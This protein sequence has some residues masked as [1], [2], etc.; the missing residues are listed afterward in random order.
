MGAFLVS[1]TLTGNSADIIEDAIASVVD[2]VDLCL[3]IDTGVT[4]S[5]REIAKRVAKE[6][7]VE[8]KFPWID[9]FAA[10]RNFAL[11]AANELAEESCGGR[12]VDKWAMSVDTDERIRTNGED[13][14]KILEAATVDTF[15]VMHHSETHARERIFRLPAK[16]RFSGPTHEAFA[17]GSFAVLEKTR[18]FELEKTKDDL[19]KK[20]AR[21]ARMLAAHCA[22]NP[23]DPR[24]FYYL[25]DALQNQ[26]KYTDAIV[27]FQ[28]C[29]DLRGWDEESAWACF[30][31]AQCYLALKRYTRAIDLCAAG[32]ARHAGIAELAWLAGIASHRAANPRQAVWWA[33]LAIATGMFEG[34]G[35]EVRRVGFRDLVGLYE[36]PYDVLRH[37][38]AEV[39]EEDAAKEAEQKCEAAKAARARLIQR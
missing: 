20:F 15:M 9:D 31:A 25:G 23:T 10:A 29:A 18:C 8:R 21:D 24:W 17:T 1:T 22:T 26:G 36:G 13:V 37:A 5:T 14:R 16:G 3:V 7:Y 12:A 2:W 6:K 19:E 34:R 4:D 38:L 35:A 28:E 11:E 27:A 30:R 39:G 32:L 33:R